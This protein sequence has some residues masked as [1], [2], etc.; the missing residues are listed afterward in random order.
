MKLDKDNQRRYELLQSAEYPEK[1]GMLLSNA[2]HLRRALKIL[3][4]C[5][6]AGTL[7]DYALM[8]AHVDLSMT[9]YLAWKPEEPAYADNPEYAEERRL[10]E[11]AT[12]SRKL[13]NGCTKESGV[14]LEPTI[15]DQNE[16]A[17]DLPSNNGRY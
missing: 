13:P 4:D 9:E 15:R 8:N 6:E 2:T 1:A 12:E 10:N 5:V 16:L 14:V 3:V 7:P 17:P 11:Y